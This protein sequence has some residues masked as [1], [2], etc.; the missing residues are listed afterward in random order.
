MMYNVIIKENIPRIIAIS[1]KGN[2]VLFLYPI[3][4]FRI[5]PLG[6]KRNCGFVITITVNAKQYNNNANIVGFLFIKVDI[7]F[8][9]ML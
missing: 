1:H 8:I 6:K 7:C 9:Y 4:N 5:P 3:P 2:I